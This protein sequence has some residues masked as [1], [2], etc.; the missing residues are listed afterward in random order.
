ML[1]SGRHLEMTLGGK[2]S[3]PMHSRE[4]EGVGHFFWRFGNRK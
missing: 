2:V 3:L 4:V 1:L